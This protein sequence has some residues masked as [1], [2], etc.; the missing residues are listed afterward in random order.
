MIWEYVV[1]ASSGLPGPGFLMK[2][3][4]PWVVHHCFSR[5]ARAIRYDAKSGTSANQQNR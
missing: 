1:I 5:F 2:C 4:E 3:S